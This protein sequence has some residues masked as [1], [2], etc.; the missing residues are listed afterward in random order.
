MAMNIKRD[1]QFEH[2]K[3]QTKVRLRSAQHVWND[4]VNGLFQLDITHEFLTERLGIDTYISHLILMGYSLD[5][6]LDFVDSLFYLS[7]RSK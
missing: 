5:D 1:E 3:Q 6:I 7:D 4:K 2:R